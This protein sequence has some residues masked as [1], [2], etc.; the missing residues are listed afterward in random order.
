MVAKFPAH[1]LSIRAELEKSHESR[2]PAFKVFE[3]LLFGALGSPR[4]LSVELGVGMSENHVV[5]LASFNGI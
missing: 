3:Q 2:I 1:Y 5:K 4:F